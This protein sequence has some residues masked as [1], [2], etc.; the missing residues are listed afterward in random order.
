MIILGGAPNLANLVCICSFSGNI[1]KLGDKPTNATGMGQLAMTIAPRKWPMGIYGDRNCGY[2][3]MIHPKYEIHHPKYENMGL[4]GINHPMVCGG[5]KPA[6][7]EFLWSPL[8]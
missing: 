6:L 8:S 4:M 1:L 5:L 3:G 7:R 2:Y